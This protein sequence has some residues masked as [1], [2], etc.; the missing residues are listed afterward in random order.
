MRAARRGVPRHPRAAAGAAHRARPPGPHLHAGE[1]GDPRA[2]GRLPGR[3]RRRRPRRRDRRSTVASRPWTVTTSARSTWS[4]RSSRRPGSA[5]RRRSCG[6]S[7]TRCASCSPP[8]ATPSPTPAS[9]APRSSR[10]SARWCSSRCSPPST[11]WSRRRTGCCGRWRS[12]TSPTPTGARCSRSGASSAPASSSPRRGGGR[13]RPASPP[14]SRR[15]RATTPSA[16]PSGSPH[17]A[18][19]PGD[20]R[21]AAARRHLRRRRRPRGVLHRGEGAGVRPQPRDRR[22]P[23]AGLPPAGDRCTS[24]SRSSTTCGPA[25]ATSPS[26]GSSCTAASCTSATSRSATRTA[27]YLGCLEATQDVTAIRALT[28]ERR[29]LAEAPAAGR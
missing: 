1:P 15:W 28:G 5:P 3:A 13:V 2:D 16:F 21:H 12:S 8:A 19:A 7:T 4:S 23:G 22:P 6:A 29:L 25:R 20:A 11:G 9:S 10:W 27:A 18:P 14:R 24:S 26:S 17:A